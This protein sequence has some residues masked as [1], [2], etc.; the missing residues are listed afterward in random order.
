MSQPKEMPR[1]RTDDLYTGL[2]DA[3]FTADLEALRSEVR[4]RT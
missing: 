3:R 2:D 4:E 1:W